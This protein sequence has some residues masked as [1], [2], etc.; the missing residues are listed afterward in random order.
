MSK[1][2]DKRMLGKQYRY[3]YVSTIV[4]SHHHSDT[5][6]HTDH[7]LDKWHHSQWIL[8]TGDLIAKRLQIKD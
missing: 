1:T 3:A 6:T 8:V 2:Y 4:D 5:D 7:T